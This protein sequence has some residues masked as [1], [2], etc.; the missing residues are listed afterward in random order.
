MIVKGSWDSVIRELR[1]KRPL[2]AVRIPK[3]W[4][5]HPLRIKGMRQGI[6]LLRGQSADYRMRLPDGGALHV[7]EYPAYYKAHLDQ[8]D[9][10]LDPLDHLRRDAPEVFTAAGLAL[11]A[12]TGALVAP[13]A[14]TAGAAVGSVVG[15][16][17]A[18][19]LTRWTG[20]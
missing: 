8:V 3:D 4:F 20:P 15:A 14:P 19:G 16:S 5:P 12:I 6:G 1:S 18:W 17:A 11:G 9:P 7:R 10:V 13:R 2:A